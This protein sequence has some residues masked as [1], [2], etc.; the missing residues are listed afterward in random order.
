[1]NRLSIAACALLAGLSLLATQSP[2]RAE[3]PN[4][5]AIHGVLSEIDGTLVEGETDLTLLLYAG[6]FETTP[7]WTEERTGDD[8]VELQRG[9][10]SLYLGEVTPL[11]PS[12]IANADELWLALKVGDDDEMTR[13]RFP[14]V[15]YAFVASDVRG[16]IHPRSISVDGKP[17]IDSTG[18]WVGETSGVEGPRGEPGES[19]AALSL[20][21]GDP[22]CPNGGSR[23][24]VGG[25]FTYACNGATGP[26]GI[27]G[28]VG[29]QG[30][31]GP[32]NIT[33]ITTGAGLT[34]GGSTP[35]V[36]I[37]IADLGVGAVQLAANAVTTV[38]VSDLA[39]TDAKLG[40]NAVTTTK[41]ADLA[42]TDAKLAANA[43]TTAK[44]ANL[45]ISDAKLAA[46]AVTTTKVAD[47]AITD[48]KLALN[49][50][51]TTKVADLAIT[52][53]KLAL[54]AV[55]TT[56][57][58]DLAIT[59]AKLALNAV[60]TT[61]VADLAI[62]DA[63][64]AA[65]AVT[66]VKIN[67]LAV[68]EA[69]LANGAVANA[70]LGAN[71]VT[72]DKIADGSVTLAKT[73]LPS[74]TVIGSTENGVSTWFSTQTVTLGADDSCIV[75]VTASTTAN[76]SF[77]VR[78]VLRLGANTVSLNN[79]GHSSTVSSSAGQDFFGG[80]AA[81]ATAVLTPTAA[82]NWQVGCEIPFNPTTI[83]CAVS[84]ICQ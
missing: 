61:K 43:V 8:R 74:A 40:L 69:K 70:K 1:M 5:I 13:I 83:E 77:R 60:T 34:G 9:Y 49:A 27:Q 30:P 42:I 73:K 53:A 7:I 65:N 25:A 14:S 81:S 4:L 18:R 11:D 45:A 28:E 39:I 19:V 10:F 15:P 36:S 3:V 51:T 21:T 6:P 16:D 52:D 79:F 33:T 17:I 82:G 48:A 63:K 55:T 12:I 72:T 58:A 23:F 75:A 22:D 57:V 38:K 59:D 78:P 26:Q 66:T 80:R 84:Y 71:A 35:T 50:V 44:V 24:G 2:V 46:N 20:G 37:G 64:L 32:D 76:S 47:L 56:K 29:P 54:N 31:A 67:N 41:V 62:T 68:T